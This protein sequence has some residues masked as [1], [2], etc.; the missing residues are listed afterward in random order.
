MAAAVVVLVVVAAG[1]VLL[2]LLLLLHHINYS[3]H[4]T[5]VY[6]VLTF[7]NLAEQYF[8]LILQS[9]LV[10]SP[11]VS[12]PNLHLATA[13]PWDGFPAMHFTPISRHPRLSPSPRHRGISRCVIRPRLLAIMHAA[14][15]SPSKQHDVT[16]ARVLPLPL[17]MTPLTRLPHFRETSVQRESLTASSC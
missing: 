14:Q 9:I 5:A 11:L 6:R 1:T 16:V 4:T 2:L 8:K 7:I 10:S 13:R 17:L 3:H 15:C 12:S